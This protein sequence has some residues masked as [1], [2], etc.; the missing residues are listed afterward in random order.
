MK[1]AKDLESIEYLH[2]IAARLA[3]ILWLN[4][5]AFLWMLLTW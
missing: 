3:V 2:L 5:G 1:T 4:L